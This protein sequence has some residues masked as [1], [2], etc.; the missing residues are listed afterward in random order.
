MLFSKGDILVRTYK[1]THHTYMGTQW[2]DACV[3]EN[4]V[5]IYATW[6]MTQMPPIE[7]RQICWNKTSI[8][9]LRNQLDMNIIS[10]F[11]II[12][13][14]LEIFILPRS[15]LYVISLAIHLGQ[16]SINGHITYK[17]LYLQCSLDHPVKVDCEITF[18][19][20]WKRWPKY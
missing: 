18:Y 15:K 3:I 1:L 12:K 17:V 5:E 9:M 2:D 7:L 19:V 20:K 4:Q 14:E 16:S 11:K 13:Y 10:L 8:K 6:V